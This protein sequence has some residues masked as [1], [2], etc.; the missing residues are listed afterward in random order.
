MGGLAGLISLGSQWWT[1]QHL[2]PVRPSA[3]IAWLLAGLGLRWLVVIGLFMA[4]Q[5]QG[6]TPALA[7]LAGLWLARWAGLVWLEIGNR[8][9]E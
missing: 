9:I 7:V 5:R 3:G 4:A 1:V 6:L 8:A 2:R